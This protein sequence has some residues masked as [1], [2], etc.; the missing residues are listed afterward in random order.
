MLVPV[1]CFAMWP[2]LPSAAS[3]Q[4][5]PG[6]PTRGRLLLT[7]SDPTGAIL[8]GAS[9]TVTGLEDATKA[10]TIA[11]GK[12]SD[13][14]VATFENLA[15]GRYSVQA[16][17]AGFAV[18]VLKEVRVRAGDNRQAITLA[19]QSLQSSVTVGAD[20]QESASDRGLTFGSVLTREQI[21]A[22]SDNPEEMRRQIQAMVG[23][24]AE[25]TV[26]SFEGAQLPPKSQIKLIRVSRDQFAAEKH[27]AAAIS[28]DIVT[29][30]GIGPLRGSFGLGVYNSV[31]DG[32][33]PMVG[34]TPPSENRTFNGSLGGTVIANK[35]SFQVGLYTSNGFS[36]PVQYAHTPDGLQSGVVPIRA[37]N[38]NSSLYG[39]L[40]YAMTRD[41]TLRITASRYEFTN[42]NMGIDGANLPER[43]FSNRSSGATIRVQEVG[44]LGRRFFMNSRASITLNEFASDSAIEAVAVVVPDNFTSGGAQ[45]RGST[46]NLTLSLASDLDYVRGRHSLRI[47]ALLDLLAYRTDVASNYLGT[48][49]FESLEAFE[50]GLP[51]SF[52]RRVGDPEIRYNNVQTGLYLQDDIRVNRSLTLT[53]GLR[54]EAQ[55]L[56]DDYFNLAPRFGITWAPFRGG[57]TTL[58]GS[59][60]IFYDWLPTG[61]YEQ[62]LRIDGFRQ[63]EINILNPSYPD[64]G[65]VGEA[66]PINRYV[67]GDDLELSR[68]TR[69]SAG[70]SQRFGPRLTVN[71][72]Y[73]YTRYSNTLVGNNLNAPVEGVRPDPAFANIIEA[74]TLGRSLQHSLASNAQLN[75]GTRTMVNQGG[76]L[77]AWGRGLFLSGGYTYGTSYNNTD[78]AFA[79][80][81]SNSLDTEWGPAGGDI[82]HRANL[83][84]ATGLLRNFSGNINVSTSSA[85]PITIRT[86]TDD[87]ADLIFNDRP[88]FIGRNTERTTGQFF[89][90]A[91]FSYFIGLGNRQVNTGPGISIT[92]SGGGGLSAN[93]MDSQAV[94]R[95]RLI[96]SVSINNLTNRPN[97][98]GYSGVMTS[99]S[100]LQPTTATGTRRIT[101]NVGLTF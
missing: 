33:N 75:I 71:A 6:A 49:N 101:F 52:T 95:Y 92:Q 76:P 57:T 89:S 46:R 74:V 42:E 69:L 32:K 84:L 43:A 2:L 7:V 44:P 13:T 73:A 23:A 91:Y 20:A 17:F 93:V 82:R 26:D 58:R 100:F 53:P 34:E 98:T 78:G 39:Q 96:F 21:D 79:T 86:G 40:D 18:G 87:N 66:P 8:A 97:Y 15:P 54:Y 9:V 29:Q 10:A 63:K 24:D 37:P 99:K 11:P 90:N 62:T 25:I 41:Q 47:G 5:R 81:A 94:A 1:V 14:G 35:M 3:A 88:D 72:T 77:V 83:S 67:F 55:S 16:E 85:P 19:L 80:P 59:A 30:P 68:N 70:V 45:Q 28:I 64:P 48:Y 50:A 36:T 60:G 22:L 31:L 4:A 51:R 65:D 56:A 61:T 27:A 38:S 12:T